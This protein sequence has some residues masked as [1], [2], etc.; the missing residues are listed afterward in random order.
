MRSPLRASFFFF[1]DGKRQK[2]YI[3][4]KKKYKRRMRNPPT[5]ENLNYKNT[6]TRIYNVK[7]NKLSGLVSIE[8]FGDLVS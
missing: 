6:K 3:D 8:G 1:F 7:I 2:R 5:K 4:S